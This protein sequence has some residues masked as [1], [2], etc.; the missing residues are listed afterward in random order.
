M[1][2]GSFTQEA[3]KILAL[4]LNAGALP[5]PVS[6]V[7]KRTIGATLGQESVAKSLQAGAIGLAIVAV[8]M[9]AK[10]GWLGVLC[11]FGSYSVWT[12]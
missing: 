9:I 1:I 7:E 5:V 10:Y 3:A 4:Q 8:F 2:T 12:C 11:R 6:I